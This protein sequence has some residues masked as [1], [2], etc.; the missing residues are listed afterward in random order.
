MEIRWGNFAVGH[1]QQYD[2]F[3][4]G[5]VWIG[6][7]FK[8][9]FSRW[10]LWS[11]VRYLATLWHLMKHR[12]LRRLSFVCLCLR[13]HSMDTVVASF[14]TTMG[15]DGF[16]SLTGHPS[17]QLI[18]PLCIH[19]LILSSGGMPHFQTPICFKGKPCLCWIKTVRFLLAFLC[20]DFGATAQCPWECFGGQHPDMTPVVWCGR[21]PTDVGL[22]GNVCD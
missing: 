15:F 20:R 16:V 2:L 1:N 13:G 18:N 12:I 3:G 22:R 7:P 6:T 5:F 10:I 19:F 17:N 8:W 11:I 9:Q 4:S 14:A 21:R